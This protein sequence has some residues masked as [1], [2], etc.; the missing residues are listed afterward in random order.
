MVNRLSTSVADNWCIKTKSTRLS[1]KITVVLAACF[2]LAS[3]AWVFD[4]QAAAPSGYQTV[5]PTYGVGYYASLAMDSTGNPGVSYFDSVNQDLKY[6]H[7]NGLFWDIQTVDAA[8]STGVFTSL[9][10]DSQGNPLISYYG[11]NALKLARWVGNPLN[12][13]HIDSVDIGG[14]YTSLALDAHGN[15]CISYYSKSHTLNFVNLTGPSSDWTPMI[16]D[17]S[18]ADVGQFTSLKIASNGTAYI[19]YYD[20]TN[21]NLKIAWQDSA[22]VW[23]TQTV[24]PTG[25]VGQYS[26]LAL[27]SN[28]TRYISYYDATYRQLKFAKSTPTGWSTQ[29]VESGDVGTGNSIAVD[30]LGN[31]HFSYI[32]NSTS[33]LLRYS[34]LYANSSWVHALFP[35]AGYLAEYTNGPLAPTSIKINTNGTAV[36]IAYHDAS[37]YRLKYLSFTVSF[38]QGGDISISQPDMFLAVTPNPDIVN[39]PVQATATLPPP[40]AGYTYTGIT[41]SIGYPNGSYLPLDGTF[42]T[43]NGTVT[44]VFTPTLVGTY[45]LQAFFPAQR[46]TIGNTTAYYRATQSNVVALDVTG[47]GTSIAL[48]VTPNP[49][50]VNQTATINIAVTPPPTNGPFT[51]ISYNITYPNGTVSTIGGLSTNGTGAVP[52]IVFTPTEVGTYTLQAFF[53]SQTIGAV[54]YPSAI[55]SNVTL[56]VQNPADPTPTP[57][58]T[59]SDSSSSSSNSQS[60]NNQNTDDTTPDEED[61]DETIDEVDDNGLNETEPTQK[62]DWLPGTF[63]VFET[64]LA[65]LIA[66]IACIAAVL[67]LKRWD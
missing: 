30:S 57:T 61:I 25:D 10:Y 49:D 20:V 65:G 45:Y 43:P 2:V 52:P 67:I 29:V 51:G 47:V 53:P 4:V 55:S 14:N 21:G 60:S 19:S 27:D 48:S 37:D 11:Q 54:T 44:A 62:R 22:I 58:A 34:L 28:G 36:Y 41:Y 64:I 46:F 59:P 12:P 16:V 39:Q 40:P 9:V 13:W 42:S 26:S 56:V 31:V 18:V 6:A 23:Q 66:C 32:D 1:L 38:G 17:N 24:D 5:D 15:P 50:V 35:Y 7:W 8:G 63:P 3:P 33:H